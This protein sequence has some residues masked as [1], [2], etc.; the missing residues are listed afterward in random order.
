[1]FNKSVFG[2]LVW[3][4]GME[5]TMRIDVWFRQMGFRA[6]LDWGFG[7]EDMGLVMMY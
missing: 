3:E 7:K 6:C 4:W 2:L 5:I 1:M